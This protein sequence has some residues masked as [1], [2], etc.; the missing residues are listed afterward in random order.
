MGEILNEI[1]EL[2]P[3][4]ACIKV[5]S[6]SR[7]FFFR[8]ERQMTVPAAAFGSRSTGLDSFQTQSYKLVIS[9]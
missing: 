2:N 1:G 3:A 9:H 6:S 8:K 4:A 7:R 5:D